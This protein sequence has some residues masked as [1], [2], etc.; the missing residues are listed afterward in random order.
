MSKLASPRL[1]ADSRLGSGRGYLS[2]CSELEIDG[3]NSGQTAVRKLT[4]QSQAT[5]YRLWGG[6]GNQLCHSHQVAEM[7]DLRQTVV[8]NLTW[9]RLEP[10]HR[11]GSR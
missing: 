6:Q 9:L 2:Y 5:N 8:R 3:R 4:A 11:L 10:E 1:A 7:R